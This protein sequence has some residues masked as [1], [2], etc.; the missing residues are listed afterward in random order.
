MIQFRDYQEQIMKEKKEEWRAIPNYEGVYD[1]SSF[2]RIRNSKT[3]RVLKP[4][5]VKGYLRNTLSKGNIQNRFQTHRLVALC[6]IPNPENKPCVNHI[7]GVKTN[8]RIDNLD[9]CTY[10]EN[11]RHSYD[12]IGKVNG[13]RKLS[14]EAVIDIRENLIKGVNAK[15]F[16]LKYSVCKETVLNVKNNKYYV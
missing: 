11:E 15:H 4:E 2:G 12:L 14:K 9:W 6:F 16:A 8:N 1:A 5:N 13:N 10:S 7:D 3:G